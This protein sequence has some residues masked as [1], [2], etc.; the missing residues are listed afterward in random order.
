MKRTIILIIAILLVGGGLKAQSFPADSAYYKDSLYHFGFVGFNTNG[1]SIYTS[2]QI[3]AEFP[4]G[5]PGWIKYL[6]SK[7]RGSVGNRYIKIPDGESSAI[8]VV[9]VNFVVNAYGEVDSVT[10][11]S[12]TINNVHPR[13]VNEALRVIK[14][15][16]TWTP[17]WQNGKNVNYRVKQS[18][19]FTK[20]RD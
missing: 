19:V 16:P 6:K 8:E 1:D 2:I 14:N 13:I 20:S 12:F 11:D 5:K 4:G 17:A 10:T 7:T 18:I 15:S 9:P 3:E